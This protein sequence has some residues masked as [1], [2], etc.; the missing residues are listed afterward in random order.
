[1]EKNNDLSNLSKNNL[2]IKCKELG[3][4]KYYS[5]NK[6]DLIKLIKN[7]QEIKPEEVKLEDVKLE[8][9][10]LEG[11]KLEIKQE[12]KLEDVKPEIKLEKVKIGEVKPEEVKY[13]FIELCAGGG[14]LSSGLI[15]AGFIP[16]LLNDNNK[17]CCETLKRNHINTNVILSP[18]E[19]IDLTPYI[20]K[21]D[22]LTGGIPCQSYSQSGLRKGLDDPRGHLIYPF[23]KMIETVKPKIFMIENVKGLITHNDGNTITEIINLLDKE[24]LY[25][26]EYKLLNS[27]DYSVPQKRERVFII[28][29]L[30]SKNLKFIFPEKNEKIIVLKDVLINVPIS[31]GGKYNEEK[32]KLFKLIP[33][34]GCWINLPEDKQKSYLGKSYLSG[35]GK[36]GIL[37]RLSMEKPSLTLLCTPSQKQTERCHPLEERP[38]NIREYARIQTF[39]DNY[40]FIGSMSSQYKQIG[41]A[42]PIE[43]A[44][45]IGINLIN[46]LKN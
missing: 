32:K 41:N 36:R 27:A 43:L 17:D 14:G 29:T 31:I 8:D 20:N 22:L 21:V 24:K 4:T 25:N 12:I 28:G 16:L 15:K 2:L 5:K 30:K 7:K 38:L 35:G 42:V 34:G 44:R 37:Y 13:T 19:K 46:T 10:K 39:S 40:V 26:I 6:S 18:M 9:V 3:I 11:V 1:M 45:Q 23:V 33:Q